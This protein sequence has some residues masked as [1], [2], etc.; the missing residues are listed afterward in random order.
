ME[1]LNRNDHTPAYY[2]G[3][4]IDF[5]SVKMCA[6]NMMIHGM[7]GRAIRH[8]TLMEPVSFDYVFEINEVRY[9]FPTPFYSLRKIRYKET[10]EQRKSRQLQPK[11]EQTTVQKSIRQVVKQTS[12]PMPDKDGQYSLF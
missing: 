6:L 8:D 4:D 5:S 7:H 3:E 9:P 1:K 2:Q 10:E 11:A 12:T